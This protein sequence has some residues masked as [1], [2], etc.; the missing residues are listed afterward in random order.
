LKSTT[1]APQAHRPNLSKSLSFP[2][3]SAG[4][5][6]MKKSI[7][8]TFVK[9][10]TKHV[11]GARAQPS[12]RR[13][14]RLTNNEVNSKES[15]KNTGNSNHRTSLTSMNSLKSSKVHKLFYPSIPFFL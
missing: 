10:E 13:S 3:K 7:N 9:T 15:E 12:V 6:V 4:G 2:A 11:N 14:S 5:D 8:G 1:S